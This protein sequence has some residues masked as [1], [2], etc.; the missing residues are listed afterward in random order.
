MFA[1]VLANPPA[2]CKVSPSLEAFLR[3]EIARAGPISWARFME[4]ALY[5]PEHGYYE[6]DPNVV[7]RCGDFYTSVS[8]G[9]LFGQL[10]AC[11]F[12]TWLEERG[13]ADAPLQ[14]VEAGAHDGQLAADILAWLQHWRP[15]L[16]ARLEYWILEPSTRRQAWQG[17]RLSAFAPRV[18]WFASWDEI[19]ANTVAGVIFANELLDAFPLHRLAWHAGEQRWTEWGVHWADGR[20]GWTPLPRLEPAVAMLADPAAALSDLD[21]AQRPAAWRA[22]AP[23]L[24]DGFILE[25]AP[26]AELWWAEA[27]SRLRNGRLLTLDYGHLHG[28]ALHP[29]KPNGTLRAYR[30]HQLMADL[31][32]AP[33]SQDI[34]AHVDFAGVARAGERAGLTTVELTEQSRFLTRIAQRTMQA[35]E[36]FGEWT[37]ARTRQFQTLAHP[38]HLGRSFAALVQARWA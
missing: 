13:M 29:A 20:F 26:S 21:A 4:V 30:D 22:I 1:R 11:Q 8:V 12:A 38:D 15:A 6:R 35:P 14:I 32:A 16:W 37:R 10:L 28:T 23:L 5:H 7:G 18:R 2:D 36:T 27:A 3:A 33:G 31:L 34:T 9:E 19:S 24:P 17:E 25:R